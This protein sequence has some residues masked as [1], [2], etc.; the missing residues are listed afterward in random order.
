MTQEQA[1]QANDEWQQ[2][3]NDW[4]S[5][6]PDIVKINKRI[7]WVTWR[8]FAVLALDAIVVLSYIPFLVY[9]T[10][11][12]D[13]SLAEII[14]TYTMT[15][16]LFYGVYW[17]FKLRLPLF[18]LDSESTKDILAFYL[19]RVKAGI[20]LGEL[21]YKFS[22]FLIGAFSVWVSSS[23]YFDLGEEKLQKP[24]FIIFGIVWVSIM[25]G[26]MYWYKNKKQKE[27]FRLQKLWKE[28]LE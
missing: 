9:L 16:V 27:Y 23:F 22:L 26:I 4:Q 18:K 11:Y 20:R 24:S 3:Q 7:A 12:E 10:L 5:Y 21:G 17:D 8:M 25:A 1:N 14:W 28:F 15:P 13:N 19:K 6:Q 2:L